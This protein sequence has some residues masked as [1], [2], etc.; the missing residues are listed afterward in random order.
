[1]HNEISDGQE[2]FPDLITSSL[3]PE[4][5][6]LTIVGDLGDMEQ[7]L[8]QMISAAHRSGCEKLEIKALLIGTFTFPQNQ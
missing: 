7:M 8:E 6:S 4:D 5:R 3:A 2:P 1:M